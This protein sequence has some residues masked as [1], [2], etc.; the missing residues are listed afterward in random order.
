MAQTNTYHPRILSE[1]KLIYIKHKFFVDTSMVA[2]LWTIIIGV[3]LCLK[4]DFIYKE[5]AMKCSQLCTLSPVPQEKMKG[6]ILD[7]A[8]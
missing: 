4:E 5:R 3:S 7:V 8:S 6:G 2:I 1:L